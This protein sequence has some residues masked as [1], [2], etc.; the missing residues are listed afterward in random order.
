MFI[1]KVCA[2][3]CFNTKWIYNDSIASSLSSLQNISSSLLYTTRVFI[4]SVVLRDIVLQHFIICSYWMCIREIVWA[5]F[6]ATSA[7][8][9]VRFVA[10]IFPSFPFSFQRLLHIP[11]SSCI[12]NTFRN[13]HFFAV[14]FLPILE[15]KEKKLIQRCEKSIHYLTLS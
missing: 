8:L 15:R 9:W 4:L 14:I 6:L 1:G 2:T 13:S 3:N 10:H 12:G 7:P 5:D 11:Y